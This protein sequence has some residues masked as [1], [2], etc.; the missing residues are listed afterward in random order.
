MLDL[1]SEN[2]VI[3]LSSGLIGSLLTFLFSVVLK[4][5]EARK[6]R[7]RLCH[8]F[9]V[10]TSEPRALVLCMRIIIHKISTRWPER[11]K[12]FYDFC[13]ERNISYEDGAVVLFYIIMKKAI[14]DSGEIERIRYWFLG[15]ERSELSDL[16]VCDELFHLLPEVAQFDYSSVREIDK[17]LVR[18]F[19]QV[20]LMVEE[21]TF[22]S[23][24]P[25]W[26]REGYKLV[27]RAER[28]TS[29]LHEVLRKSGRISKRASERPVHSLARR[30]YSDMTS[31][32]GKGDT[33]DKAVDEIT[34]EK[35][36]EYI[37]DYLAKRAS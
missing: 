20:Q 21:E 26:L 28:R 6:T 11:L 23:L 2:V 3:A 32:I 19:R 18:Y 36:E 4:W 5:Y 10:R 7:R 31:N 29:K 1:D 27:K 16:K 30:F 9:I 35:V 22:E 12:V 13:E 34:L 14:G 24:S 8:A 33:F 15:M 37:E 17:E 25:E